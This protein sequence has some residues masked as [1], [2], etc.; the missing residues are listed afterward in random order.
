MGAGI[1]TGFG[2]CHVDC[3][4]R[5]YENAAGPAKLAPLIDKASFLVENLNTVIFPVPY[6]QAASG[7]HGD[8]MRF[9]ELSGAR[10][11]AAPGFYIGSVGTVVNNSIV[12]SVTM[13]LGD[14][15][16]SVTGVDNHIVWPKQQIGS[17]TLNT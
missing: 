2:I 11:L 10:T 12:L 5:S 6:E 15:D 4:V 16:I 3:V 8:T 1:G 14:E 7:I 17:T 9:A 13:T